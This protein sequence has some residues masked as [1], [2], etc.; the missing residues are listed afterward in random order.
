MAESEALIYIESDSKLGLQAQIRQKL[1]ESIHLGIFKP[2]TRLPSSR[3]LSEQL[4]VA[5]NTV[6]IACQQLVAEGLLTSRARS[7]LY[8]ARRS[9]STGL[10][11]GRRASLDRRL[12]HQTDPVA[13][14]GVRI[15]C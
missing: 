1:V 4:G 8:V 10:F 12:H 14:A 9:G 11:A 15:A 2:G 5:R 13:N 6:V 3:K 7:G